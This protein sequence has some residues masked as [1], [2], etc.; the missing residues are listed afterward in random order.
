METISRVRHE[1]G[2]DPETNMPAA[3]EP[4]EEEGVI[5]RTEQQ[6]RHVFW[7]IAA[8][9][10]RSS[11]NRD[12]AYNANLAEK[13]IDYLK[14]HYNDPSL[15]MQAL[16]E[17]FHLSAATLYRIFKTAAKI[18]FYDC[19]SRIRIDQAKRYLEE[20]G[21]TSANVAKMVGYESVQ[22]FNRA[23]LRYEG[24]S[25]KDYALTHR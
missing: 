14:E 3:E 6:W 7:R 21:Y 8:L 18:N 12:T 1:L 4:L 24:I 9:C 11:D 20:G 25:P 5:D 2:L 16:S 10:S 15:S 23:F 19:L 22:S 13:L 17:Q